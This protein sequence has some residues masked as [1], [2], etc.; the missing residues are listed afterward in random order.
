MKQTPAGRKMVLFKL[1][2]EPGSKIF[3]AGTFNNWNPTDLPLKDNPRNG[4]YRASVPLGTGK[5][6]Y[7]F[8]INGKWCKDPGC[9]EAAPDGY[10]A[11]NSV[12]S[13]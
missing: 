13:V 7:K 8:V 11:M 2:A 5:H 10:G 4:D 12:V 1:S 9:K 3:V 6:Q